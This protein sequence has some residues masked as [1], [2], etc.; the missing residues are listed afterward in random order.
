[1]GHLPVPQQ[2]GQRPDGPAGTGCSMTPA[3]GPSRLEPRAETAAG[4]GVCCHCQTSTTADFAFGESF[5]CCCLRAQLLI[6]HT[7]GSSEVAFPCLVH[8][9]PLFQGWSN[10]WQPK[11][12]GGVSR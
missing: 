1:M 9:E 7:E 8:A 11:T 6:S 3:Y 10:G 5:F 12:D 4:K 2:R